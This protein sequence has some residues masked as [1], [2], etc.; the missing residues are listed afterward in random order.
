MRA[1]TPRRSAPPGPGGDDRRRVGGSGDRA[2]RVR[3]R[4]GE[5]GRAHHRHGRRRRDD[6]QLRARL[7]GRGRRALRRGH[8]PLPRHRQP[9]HVQRASASRRRASG[10]TPRSTSSR[11]ASRATACACGTDA[12][13]A[14]QPPSTGDLSD[15]SVFVKFAKPITPD[16]SIGLMGAFELSQ[17]TLLPD[18]G[19]AADRIPHLVLAVGRRRAST[20]TPTSTGRPARASSSITTTRR[21]RR[22]TASKSGLLRSYEYRLGVAYSPWKGTLLDVGG[23]ALDRSNALEHTPIVRRLPDRRRR[24]GARAEARLGARGS[25]RDDLDDRDERGASRR[26]RSTSPTSTTSPRRAPGTCSASATRASSRP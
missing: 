2:A 1:R 10:T 8:R 21:E 11:S 17:A 15:T 9:V 13:H 4:P 18:D 19:G 7:Q 20:G 12:P 26:S 14:A 23:D 22:A 5:E 25:R 16:L 24:A 3:R 6:R